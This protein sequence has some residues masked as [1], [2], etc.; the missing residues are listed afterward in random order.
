MSDK[1]KVVKI[2]RRVVRVKSLNTDPVPTKKER[3]VKATEYRLAGKEF[4]GF[5]FPF[6]KFEQFA[7]KCHAQGMKP[8]DVVWS[9][10]CKDMGWGE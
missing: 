9:L 8:N 5:C 10:I 7:D 1:P 2:V 6:E 4:F 3:K